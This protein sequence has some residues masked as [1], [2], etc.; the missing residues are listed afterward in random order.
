MNKETPYRSI[1]LALGILVL[2]L[3]GSAQKK[4]EVKPNGYNKFYY[5]N[6]E[7]SSEGN[8]KDGKPEGYWKNY[9]PTGLLKSEGNRLNHELDSTWKFYSEE[10]VLTEEINYQNGQRS[11]VTN[12]YN[13][14]GFL[15]STVPYSDDVK[16]GVGFTYYTNG[17]VHTETPYDHGKENGKAYEFNPQGEIIAIRSFRN[18]ILTR[19]EIINRRN[20][21]GQKTGLWKEFYEGRT[22]MREGRYTNDLKNG[23]WKEYSEKGVLLQTQKYEMGKLIEDA[24]ELTNL[25]VRSQYY[26]DTDG[27]LKFRGTYRNGEPH[28]THLWF[29]EDG[30]V[31]SAQIYKNGRLIARGRMD[32]SGLRQ[33]PWVEYYYPSGEVRAEGEYVDGYKVGKWV[34]YYKSGIVEET[35]SY[36]KSGLP[37]GDWKWY[38][39]NK[40]LLREETFRNGKEN[41]WMIE[42]ND[43]GMV[44]AKGEY[45]DGR[46][47]GEWFYEVGDHKE[48]G[49]YEYGMRQGV[50]EHTYLATGEMRFE[51]EFF[52][53]LPQGK[54]VWYYDNGK[55]MLEGRYESGVKEG[56]WKRYKRDGTILITI[57][58]R[59]GNEIK[60]DGQRMKAP[61]TEESEDEG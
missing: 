39:E 40:Q 19:Q 55:K 11:G 24:E 61:K 13:K 49:N 9:Y 42:Y 25:D 10:G 57:E 12:T 35:G 5:E 26:E 23:Y 38:Y 20:R 53:D 41:G 37:T 51:G 48:I 58:Y 6:G 18:G 47:E 4:G 34:Y 8:L 21:D 31:D 44:I 22:V 56:E 16:S 30:S 14:E 7:L 3:S 52:E 59:A 1:F 17:G 45:V 2:T 33:G 27:Q 36:S 43:T 32:A 29:N 50:W 60:V 28:G 15:E 46:E 54:H